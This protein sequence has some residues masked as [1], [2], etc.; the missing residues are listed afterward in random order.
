MKQ[1]S[2]SCSASCKLLL[3]TWFSPPSLILTLISVPV[4]TGT[5]FRRPHST[6]VKWGGTWGDFSDN[7]GYI[8]FMLKCVDLESLLFASTLVFLTKW[9]LIHLSNK[10]TIFWFMTIHLIFPPRKFTASITVQ[11]EHLYFIYISVT[12]HNLR[13]NALYPQ[14]LFHSSLKCGCLVQQILNIFLPQFTHTIHQELT[15]LNMTM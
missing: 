15:S 3:S 9:N 11:K 7:C 4:S 13:D 2:D 6:Q 14:V 1:T 12:S 8:K 5:E 10:K